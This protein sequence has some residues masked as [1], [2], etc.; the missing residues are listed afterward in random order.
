[1]VALALVAICAVCGLL[2]L[3]GLA[4][5][6]AEEE[7]RHLGRDLRVLNIP[8][9]LVLTA[10]Q[11]SLA[12]MPAPVQG[13]VQRMLALSP[14]IR[15]RWLGDVDC[16]SYIREHFDPEL[17]RMFETELRGSFRGD[18]CRA[19]V[20]AR[21]G[22]FYLDLDVQLRVPL[23]QLAGANT[24]FVSVYTEDESILNAVLAAAPG[25]E[26][27]LE[28]V[29][30]IRAW[31]RYEVPHSDAQT[32]S[33]WMGPVTMLRAV[34]EVVRR[35][36]TGQSLHPEASLE[37]QCGPHVLRLYEEHGLRCSLRGSEECPP[38]RAE[39]DFPGVR[40]GIFTPYPERR[41]VA[42]P[43]FESCA[44]WGCASGGWDESP[45]AIPR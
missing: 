1:M 23:D 40:F 9:Q 34:R 4:P 20:L 36:C 7:S 42:W 33:E 32:S 39:S 19:C 3:V 22:G 11:A 8:R 2:Q 37:W 13:N 15:L 29:R 17:Q 30:Q 41:L 26:I 24:T 31:Y 21:E 44:Q 45:A 27:M 38:R 16:R 18:I 5:F 6:D 10:K 14:G 12:E 43:R 25:S 28:A 35:D